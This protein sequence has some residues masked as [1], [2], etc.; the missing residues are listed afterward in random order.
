MT[1]SQALVEGIPALGPGDT[2]KIT[3]GQYGGLMK[4]LGNGPI[5]LTYEYKHG[6]RKISER[7][8]VLECRSFTGTD[9]VDSEAVRVIKEMKRIADA[10]EKLG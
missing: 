2:R 7:T 4:A 5:I 10:V 9:A 1:P 6:K 3:W 8:A